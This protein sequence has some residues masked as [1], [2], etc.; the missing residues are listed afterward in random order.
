MV[1]TSHTCSVF[2]DRL[3]RCVVC[4]V[5]SLDFTDVVP[6]CSKSKSCLVVSA[7]CMHVCCLYACL[8]DSNS[9]YTVC[10]CVCVRVHVYQEKKLL[11]NLFMKWSKSAEFRVCVDISPFF[12][13]DLSL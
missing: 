10:V 2:S 4:M 11:S 1:H 9:M 12:C 5:H 3:A 8:A 7:V 13:V 6:T